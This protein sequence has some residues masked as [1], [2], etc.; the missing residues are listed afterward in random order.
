MKR[1]LTGSTTIAIALFV[2]SGVLASALGVRQLDR[3]STTTAVVIS[4]N[5]QA[6]DIITSTSLIKQKTDKQGVA[7]SIQNPQLLLGKVL[8][9]SKQSGDL[10]FA[11]DLTLPTSKSLSYAVPEG[12]VLFTL[13]QPTSGLPFSKLHQGD[14][15]DILVRG[16]SAV[17]TVARNV[18]LIGILKPKNKNNPG[19][20][21]VIDRL[22]PVPAGTSAGASTLVMAVRPSDVYPLASIGARDQVS[23]VLHSAHDIENG[24]QPL[25]GMAKT[26]RNVIVHSG[27]VRRTVS[28]ER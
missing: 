21:G 8:N 1:K 6:G 26:H 17:R 18:Q 3:L 27:S 15:F 14:R 12:R 11:E 5:L 24:T 4:Q 2:T 22:N 16:R 23:I 13:N 7:L 20:G 25:L 10:I 28:I 19:Q 9:V